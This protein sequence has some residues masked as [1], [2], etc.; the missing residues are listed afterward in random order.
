[1][2]NKQ[3][4]AVIS[5]LALGILGIGFVAAFPMG[6]GGFNQGLTAEEMQTMKE[7]QQQM[8]DAIEN[9][10]YETWKTLMENRID[11]MKAELT[12]ENFNQLVER[13]SQMNE[14][15]EIRQQIR[16]AWENDDFETVEQLQA[17]LGDTAPPGNC[18]M[19]RMGMG[20]WA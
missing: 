19:N 5:L 2:E 14:A 12:E 1:M 15:R 10:D 3:K 18:G 20:P 4:I 8:M 11:E 17:Q 13:H 7:E 6:F 9:G 16:E